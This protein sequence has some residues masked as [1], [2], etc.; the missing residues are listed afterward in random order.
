MAYGFRTFDAD[1]NVLVDFSTKLTRLLAQKYGPAYGS[2]SI[3]AP[4]FS[5]NGGYAWASVVY[6][7]QEFLF[8]FGLGEPLALAPSVT[9]IGDTISYAGGNMPAYVYAVMW[10]VE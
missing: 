3:E 10:G 7:P 2:G 6:P 1:G 9:V 8:Y 4:G 5:D